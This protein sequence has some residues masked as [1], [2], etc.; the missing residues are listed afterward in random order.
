M[1]PSDDAGGNVSV[2]VPVSF[3]ADGSVM[4]SSTRLART[5]FCSQPNSAELTK[6]I[7]ISARGTV[8]GSGSCACNGEA[9]RL[10]AATAVIARRIDGREWL[11]DDWKERRIYAQRTTSREHRV[12]GVLL[13][14]G[15][16]PLATSQ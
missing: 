11:D 12:T 13:A 1:S 10:A 7:G 3:H 14:T 9:S 6:S 5:E 8:P 15:V 16:E 2:P 4:L